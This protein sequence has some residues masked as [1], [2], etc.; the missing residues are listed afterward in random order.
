AQPFLPQG[1]L[2]RTSPGLTMPKQAN[3]NGRSP[4]M[5]GV[6]FPAAGRSASPPFHPTGSL[7]SH[8]GHSTASSANSSL[9]P[10]QHAT[11]PLFA[12]A[13]PHGN[14][15]HPAAALAQALPNV[16][17]LQAS[18]QRSNPK[19]TAE[20]AKK[21]ATEKLHQFQQQRMSQ[22]ALAG[23]GNMNGMNPASIGQHNLHAVHANQ[24]PH[25]H[26]N[27]QLG[28]RNHVPQS[29][30]HTSPGDGAGD[31]NAMQRVPSQGHPPGQ[32]GANM[33][34]TG[35]HQAQGYSP[36]MRT[37][38][39]Q[40]HAQ[41]QP[42]RQYSLSYQQAVTAGPKNMQTQNHGRPLTLAGAISEDRAHSMKLSPTPPTSSASPP[43][44]SQAA[45]Q[46]MRRSA[47]THAAGGGNSFAAESSQ[48]S[49]SSA[50]QTPNQS[51]TK[52][53]MGSAQA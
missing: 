45:Q 19:L 48:D 36:L 9:N 4:S 52:P 26:P 44:V 40:A 13:G 7:G 53:S 28:M 38:T 25:G 18:I 8:A 39:A 51:Q 46:Q 3:G 37:V 50:A 31:A 41:V 1:A 24:H 11:S 16:H 27:G 2:S 32:G 22:L 47:S 20:Q 12:A 21:I 43:T 17:T 34:S 49:P 35:S 30:P 33:L 42:Q 14:P 29:R 6:S 10:S 15:A 23:A 5:L